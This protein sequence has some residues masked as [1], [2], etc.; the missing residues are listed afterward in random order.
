MTRFQHP[1]ERD[2]CPPREAPGRFIAGGQRC[3]CFS[4]S[5]STTSTATY[6]NK[7]T[8]GDYGR[9]LSGSTDS[10]LAT[11]NATVIAPKGDFTAGNI[12]AAQGAT[13]TVGATAGDVGSLIGQVVSANTDQL[14]AVAAALRPAI[15]QAS[16]A[17]KSSDNRLMITAAVAVA[18][19]VAAAYALKGR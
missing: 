10:N 15:T 11:D 17:Q 12:N 16:D 1:S 2:L 3:C 7:I 19:V 14:N 6:D 18:G 4:D 9:G 8:Q 13:V 5:K